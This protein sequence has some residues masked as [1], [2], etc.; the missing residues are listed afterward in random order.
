MIDKELIGLI[1]SIV[2]LIFVAIY[3][4]FI[5]FRDG[6]TKSQL[7]VLK[8]FDE[9]APGSVSK[10]DKIVTHPFV[11]KVGSILMLFGSLLALFY[12]IKQLK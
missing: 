6:A 8:F 2:F 12:A 10:F 5:W 1:F 9:N 11:L 3:S 4:Y 7:E